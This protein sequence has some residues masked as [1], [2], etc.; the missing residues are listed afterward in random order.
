MRPGAGASGVQPDRVTVTGGASAGRASQQIESEFLEAQLAPGPGRSVQIAS[1]IARGSVRF[2]DEA[3]G[4]E[5]NS[6]ELRFAANVGGR[7]VQEV[8]LTGRAQLTRTEEQGVSRINGPH[9]RIRGVDR[10]LEVIGPGRFGHEEDGQVRLAADWQRSMWFDDSIGTIRA[11]GRASAV[12][13]PDPL[14]TERAA[15]ERLVIQLTP[16]GSADA[17]IASG[18]GARRAREVV[19]AEAFGTDREGERALF[20][21]RRYIAD[22]GT[23]EARRLE[24]LV[25]LEGAEIHADNSAATLDVPAAGR[26]LL[27]DHRAMQGQEASAPGPNPQQPFG[28][29]LG[30]GNSLFSWQHSLH[31]NRR[32]GQLEMHQNVQGT[33]RRMEDGN[34]TAISCEQLTA[35]T[36]PALQG[37]G[38]AGGDGL[39][40]LSARAVG[41][42]HLATGPEATEGQP[43]PQLQELTAD[44]V[45]YDA[46]RGIVEAS[47]TG[48][49]IVTLINPSV[50]VPTTA[51]ALWWDMVRGTIRITQPAPIV[52]PR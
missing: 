2:S 31:Y 12:S 10:T 15:A 24:Q 25:Y 7:E 34:V 17:S 3:D 37:A 11:E 28:S 35:H 19:R 13:T 8:N 32:S 47:A 30:R 45:E 21:S 44:V 36:T 23:P 6:D 22:A 51:K 18:G 50:P 4:I 41:A 20:E 33:H 38:L 5:A 46:Q 1:A 52:A 26:V 42:V 39:S 43:L 40:L 48:D 49:N 9:V 27:V 16:G 29:G 14:T